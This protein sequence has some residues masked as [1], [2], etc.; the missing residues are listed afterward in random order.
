MDRPAVNIALPL[1]ILSAVALGAVL[2]V[3]HSIL[4]PLVLAGFLSI[5]FKPL[6]GVVR[7]LGAPTWV[8]LLLVLLM[9]SAAIYSTSV[10][11]SWGVQSAVE[12]APEYSE[13]V[14]RMIGRAEDLVAQY[15]GRIDANLLDRLE[16]VI[17]AERAVGLAGS[18]VG[19][20][21]TVLTDGTL[22]LL[23]LIFM[24]LG[25][26]LFARKL[27]VA[28]RDVTAV[29]AVRIYDTLNMK[30]LRYLRLK[31]L[32]NLFTGLV[33]YGVLEAF[34]VD[35]APVMGLLAF[36]F[37]YI[38]NIGSFIMTVLPGAIAAVQFENVGFALIIV[39]VLIVVQNLI[40]NIIEPKI[41]GTS[42]DISPVVVLFSLVFWGWMWG[43][44][45]MILSVPIMAVVKTLMEQFP[46]TK[47]LAILMGA[48]VPSS[49]E[50]FR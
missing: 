30:V 15:G 13:R 12:K 38:P 39:G 20:A 21:L 17:S 3:L 11:V 9:T 47:P 25:G 37:N 5:I 48:T 18:W 6:V 32:I 46:T 31:T 22:V 4:I 35:F 29:N 14:V 1:L 42:L 8:G 40:G 36:L 28:F 33:V 27:Q 44:V 50:E 24:V 49:S 34:G 45:G 43:I 16:Q 2:Y 23:F 26:D 19:S 10:I 41:M 7:R